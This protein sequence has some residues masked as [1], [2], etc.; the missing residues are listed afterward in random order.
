[1]RYFLLIILALGL[2]VTACSKKK[3]TSA[4]A[5]QT[6]DDDDGGGY[7]PDGQNDLFVS[8]RASINNTNAYRD[9]LYTSFGYQASNQYSYSFGCGTSLYQIFD[10]VLGQGKWYDCNSG[11]SSFDSSLVNKPAYV[12]LLFKGSTN[13]NG[14]SIY[15]VEGLWVVD[16]QYGGYEIPFQGNLKKHADGRFYFEAGALGFI[17]T[18]DGSGNVREDNFDVYYIWYSGNQRYS[19]LF[20]NV[21]V[22]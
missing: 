11:Q 21:T 3:T 5:A 7:I 8:G 20:G 13:Y 10:W 6:Y 22:Q 15:P 1:M 17:N 4:P 9:F 19:T 12:E 18:K 16:P 2:G 14:S